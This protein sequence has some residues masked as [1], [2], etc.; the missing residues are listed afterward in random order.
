MKFIYNDNNKLFHSL[1][2]SFLVSEC[3]RTDFFATKFT[4][5]VPK[6]TPINDS[7]ATSRRF[8]LLQL[9]FLIS[10]SGNAHR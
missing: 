2:S 9:A 8:F 5:M 3:D 4:S 7:P 6:W 10:S 1:R